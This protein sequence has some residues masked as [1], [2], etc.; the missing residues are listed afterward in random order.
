MRITTSTEL[1]AFLQ[2]N[3]KHLTDAQYIDLMSHTLGVYENSKPKDLEQLLKKI[4]VQDKF[5]SELPSQYETPL[6]FIEQ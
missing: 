3:F 4:D 2:I 5:L 1:K 6:F